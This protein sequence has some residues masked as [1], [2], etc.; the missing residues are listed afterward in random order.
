MNPEDPR[1]FHCLKDPDED[2]MKVL[3]QEL[4][5]LARS[6]MAAERAGH[7]LGPT[8][9]VHEAWLRLEKSSPEAWRDRSQFYAAASEA[10]RRIL[11]E[12]A[13]KRL[14]VKRGAGAEV[15]PLED[16]QISGEVEDEKVLAVHEALDDLVKQDPLKA[17]IV[18]LRFFSG[19]EHQEIATLLQVNEKTVRRHWA[20][21]KVMLYETIKGLE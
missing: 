5:I 7:T 19:M 3:Y 20:V 9:L 2:L 14:A 1:F 10:M 21:A 4:K 12:S 8:A 15:V 13:R 16:L 17:Q 11:V 18:K 6:R